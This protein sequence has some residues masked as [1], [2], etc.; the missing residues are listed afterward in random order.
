M[1]AYLAVLTAAAIASW[2][3]LGLILGAIILVVILSDAKKI[4]KSRI[5][6]MLWQP[7]CAVLLVLGAVLL[8]T[9]NVF[10]VQFD[11][12]EH[13]EG[14][15]ESFNFA[16]YTVLAVF[17]FVLHFYK[18]LNK[19]LGKVTLAVDT[20]FLIIAGL[21]AAII[22]RQYGS[23]TYYFIK[24]M[25]PLVLVAIPIMVVELVAIIEKNNNGKSA[26]YL[27]LV[28]IAFSISSIIGLRIISL[29]GKSILNQTYLHKTADLS[30]AKQLSEVFSNNK[31]NAYNYVYV[32]DVD[33]DTTLDQMV[34]QLMAAAI[35]NKDSSIYKTCSVWPN[36]G[37]YGDNSYL[38][39]KLGKE[40]ATNGC[41]GR[42]RVIVGPETY[43][44]A[45]Q[46]LPANNLVEINE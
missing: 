9:N 25:M 37:Y 7:A 18:N 44:A 23:I 42:L 30:R 31:F 29:T 26:P 5:V 15:I 34:Y 24:M 45:E 19:D 35:Y 20:Y 11:K 39:G 2:V 13:P 33:S 36:G 3:L 43:A 4:L 6:R 28:L 17:W 14:W 38:L 12:L 21:L 16:L 1:Y 22:L 40:Y 8:A 10:S 46:Y 32:Y 27:I 41:I